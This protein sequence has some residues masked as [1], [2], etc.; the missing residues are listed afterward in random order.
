MK[1]EWLVAVPST[2]AGVGVGVQYIKRVV[3]YKRH[4]CRFVLES[5]LAHH[6]LSEKTAEKAAKAFKGSVVSL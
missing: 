3:S 1:S 6:Y 4:R 2:A 5:G